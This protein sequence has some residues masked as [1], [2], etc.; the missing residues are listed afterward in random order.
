M[1]YFVD[2]LREARRLF[3]EIKFTAL[4]KLTVQSWDSF[5]SPRMHFSQ[6]QAQMFSNN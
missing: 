5:G 4:S 3:E 1:N 6:R 2:G